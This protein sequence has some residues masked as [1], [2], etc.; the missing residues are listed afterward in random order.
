MDGALVNAASHNPPSNVFY[1]VHKALEFW[2]FMPEKVKIGKIIVR[3]K[4][5][6]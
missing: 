2:S 5:I 3:K 4:G 1:M 6:L